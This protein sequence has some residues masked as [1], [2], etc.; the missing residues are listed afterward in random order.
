MDSLRETLLKN[1]VSRLEAIKTGAEFTNRHNLKSVQRSR[2][3][4]REDE[5]DTNLFRETPTIIVSVLDESSS[6]ED[7]VDSWNNSIRLDLSWVVIGQ[8]WNCENFNAALADM[9]RALFPARD[10]DFGV[11]ATKPNLQAFPLQ[12]RDGSRDGL[13]L[14]LSMEYFEDLGSPEIGA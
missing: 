8:D 1:V 10:I 6:A 11:N 12:P 13:T 4:W 5:I 7:K 14:I 2:H 3:G 9:K